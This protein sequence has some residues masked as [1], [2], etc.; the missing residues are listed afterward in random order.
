MEDGGQEDCRRCHNHRD[1]ALFSCNSPGMILDR[2]SFNCHVSGWMP[3]GTKAAVSA[4]VRPH[5]QKRALSKHG[6]WILPPMQAQTRNASR[7]MALLYR[8]IRPAPFFHWLISNGGKMGVEG[9]G[10][11][12]AILRFVIRGS[13]VGPIKRISI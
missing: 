2:C 5:T 3:R 9:V 12:S 1:I 7:A 11:K 8:D 4:D 6:K 13:H 10:M